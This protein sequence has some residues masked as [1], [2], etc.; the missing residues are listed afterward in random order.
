MQSAIGAGG[1]P[2]GDEGEET[3]KGVAEKDLLLADLPI[4]PPLDEFQRLFA[5]KMRSF[6]GVD[7]EPE[8]ESY[9]RAFALGEAM[10]QRHLGAEEPC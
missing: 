9:Q 10:I 1:A 7:G 3:A 8:S 2:S 5:K 4:R 6:E